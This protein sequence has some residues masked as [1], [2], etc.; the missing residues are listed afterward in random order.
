M[1]ILIHF[2]YTTQSYETFQRQFKGFSFEISTR[3]NNHSKHSA[4]LPYIA[5]HIL[6]KIYY[7]WAGG[8]T[9]NLKNFKQSCRKYPLNNPCWHFSIQPACTNKKCL[10]YSP[11]RRQFFVNTRNFLLGFCLNVGIRAAA[12]F[13]IIQNP[14]PANPAQ[15]SNRKSMLL[16]I[17]QLWPSSL[18][19]F[20]FNC[21]IILHNRGISSERN[22]K[23]IHCNNA[24]K[25]LPGLFQ[26]KMHL[27][28]KA[29]L[30]GPYNIF[31]HNGQIPKNRALQKRPYT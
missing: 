16:N 21:K 22:L 29:K 14:I 19:W 11:K 27:L 30:L 25:I 26:R 24:A 28:G 13:W 7:R 4:L 12:L 10:G 3:A 1:V 31:R 15:S 20:H 5:C 6:R 17:G 18:Q 23:K 9:A 8:T 2:K